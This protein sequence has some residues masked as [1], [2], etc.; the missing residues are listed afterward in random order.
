MPNQ[1]RLADTVKT[2]HF[3]LRI[4]FSPSS[5]PQKLLRSALGYASAVTSKHLEKIIGEN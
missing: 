4:F 1:T 3:G 5:L 2:V